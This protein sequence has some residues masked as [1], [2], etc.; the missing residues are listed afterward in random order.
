[1]QLKVRLNLTNDVDKLQ[2]YLKRFFLPPLAMIYIDQA[3]FQNIYY[4]GA[5]VC[6]VLAL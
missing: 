1:M 6:K 4:I 5:Y 3:D 2:N